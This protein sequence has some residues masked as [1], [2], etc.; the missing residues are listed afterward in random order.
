MQRFLQTSESP[1]SPF[2]RVR[3]FRECLVELDINFSK[4]F[5][6]LLNLAYRIAKVSSAFSVLRFTSRTSIVRLRLILARLTQ[7]RLLPIE[8]SLQAPKV[9]GRM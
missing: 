7:A 9:V 2:R 8:N 6:D 4:T 1:C 3:H 5:A